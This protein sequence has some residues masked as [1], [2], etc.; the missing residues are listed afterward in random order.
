VQ[1]E[2]ADKTLAKRGIPHR[3]LS[4]GITIGG[5]TPSHRWLDVH[6]PGRVGIFKALA[7]TETQLENQLVILARDLGVPSA[8]LSVDRPDGWPLTS[9][10]LF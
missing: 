9:A 10:S 6:L 4:N 8:L 5:G 3:S 2:L 7:A 1:H